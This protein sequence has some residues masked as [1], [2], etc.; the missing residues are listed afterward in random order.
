MKHST[1]KGVKIPGTARLPPLLG[2]RAGV[3]ASVCSN[4]IFG[5]G[6]SRYFGFRVLDFRLSSSQ[7]RNG[8]MNGGGR[9]RRALIFCRWERS[10]LDGVSPHRV[11]GK[12]I[13]VR[14]W[15]WLLA[16]LR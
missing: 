16:N 8:A 14:K 6:G 9:L 5:V 2:E 1:P 10:G 7:S 11:Q 12:S 13:V 3:R 15:R 4:S